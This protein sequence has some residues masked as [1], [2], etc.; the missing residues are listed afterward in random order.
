MKLIGILSWYDESPSWL[1]A[2]VASLARAGATHLVAVDG[3][4][5]MYPD[6]RG[7]SGGNQADA[8]IKTAY[9]AGLA[10]SLHVPTAVWHGNEVE[11]RDHCFRL[12][13][14]VAAP[15]E[16]DWYW[17]VDADEIILESSGL[18]F[19][20]ANTDMNVAET[21]LL[22]YQDP[23]ENPKT[24]KVTRQ[25]DWPRESASTVRNLFRAIPGLS[26]V[27]NHYTVTVPGQNAKLRGDSAAGDVLEPALDL[28]QSVKI[29]HRTNLR[30]LA[31]A[32]SQLEYYGLR[33]ELGFERPDWSLTAS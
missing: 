25:I 23:L 6:G 4:Y 9:G 17:I 3:A 5:R 32:K 31:R 21:T 2:T 8:I 15:H 19:D 11:K 24:A 7:S 20:L 14:T 27:E 1:S 22:E 30:D 26:T 13:E 33:E 18:V 28:S 29:E 16:E 12:A 10:L